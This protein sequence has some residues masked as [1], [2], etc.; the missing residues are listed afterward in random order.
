MTTGDAVPARIV[1]TG[2]WLPG[3]PVDNER[4][5]REHSLPVTAGWIEE[6]TGIRSRHRSGPQDT[7]ASMACHAARR[8]LESAGLPPTEIGR[9]I[10]TSS[11]GGDRRVPG[12][13]FIV[14][15]QLGARCD[16]V[17][18]HGS[19]VAWLTGLD[20]AA[21]CVAT[22]SGPVLVIAVE[23]DDG[24]LDPGDRRT[25][26]LFGEGAAAAVVTASDR[27]G[28]LGGAFVADGGNWKYLWAPG[29]AEEAREGGRTVRFG[30]HGRDIRKLVPALVGG[31]VG[32]VCAA[33]GLSPGGF[34]RVIPHQPNAA[35][36]PELL[37]GLG[38]D[39][40]GVDLFVAET[41]S[42]PSVMVPMGLDRA[43]RSSRPPQTGD[44]LLMFSV[45]AGVA[46]GAIAWEVG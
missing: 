6:W 1:G 31:V 29:P 38:I 18:L 3:E 17:D 35:W 33:A 24:V 11:L 14:Q 28:L 27:G 9:L 46:A 42:I 23:H 30:A 16:V 40:G 45:G 7:A 43:F 2:S 5:C 41:G 39:A 10:F 32:D 8:A 19:C 4:L 21:R 25:F 26:P 13:G 22:G 44:R 12:T 15:D 36:M 20:I 34:D 37:G